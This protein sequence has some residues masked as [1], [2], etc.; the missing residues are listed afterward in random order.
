MSRLP[1]FVANLLAAMRGGPIVPQKSFAQLE[2]ERRAANEI[3]RT[4]QRRLAAIE[5][6]KARLIA[7]TDCERQ[8][9]YYGK[10]DQDVYEKALQDR[11]RDAEGY[12]PYIEKVTTPCPTDA[13]WRA[14]IPG[15]KA[16]PGSVR[17]EDLP[18]V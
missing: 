14:M 10:F 5:S 18:K 16:N 15:Q 12:L 11:V 1:G 7:A 17:P 4:E 3:R 6:E 9:N 13:Q 2:A 8:L